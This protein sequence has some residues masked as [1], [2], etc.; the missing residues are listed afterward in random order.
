[1]RTYSMAVPLRAK[2]LTVVEAALRRFLI[3]LLP[4]CASRYAGGRIAT[5]PVGRELW[6]KPL[7]NE[8]VAVVLFNRAGS[9][10]GKHP[11]IIPVLI[12]APIYLFAKQNDQLKS[13]FSL[14]LLV[15]AG[16]TT[17][18]AGPLPPHCTDPESTLAPCTGCFLDGDQPW[19]APCDDNATASSG[20][21]AIC[22]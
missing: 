2:E 17:E 3:L 7:A 9:A 15:H 16:Q 14:F 18:G 20:T 4:A 6:A 5:W 1:M 11:V 10:I 12:A 22:S 21:Y 19:T 13:R 8:T